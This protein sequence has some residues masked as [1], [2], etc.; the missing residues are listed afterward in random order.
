MTFPY[1]DMLPVFRRTST[2]DRYGDGAEFAESHEIGPCGVED[3]DSTENTDN[4]EA[5]EADFTVYAPLGSDVQA[6]DRI[7]CRG[8]MCRVLGRPKVFGRHPMTGNTDTSGVVVRLV[9]SQG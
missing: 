9:H 1:G 5:V 2:R 3:G 7:Q 6:T 8:L 4:R